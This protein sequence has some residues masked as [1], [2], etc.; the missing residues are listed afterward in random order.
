MGG[1]LSHLIFRELQ[2]SRTSVN[3][4]NRKGRSVVPRPSPAITLVL[5]QPQRTSAPSCGAERPLR[6][7]TITRDGFAAAGHAPLY[8]LAAASSLYADFPPAALARAIAA[9][10]TATLVYADPIALGRPDTGAPF[11]SIRARHYAPCPRIGGAR[12]GGLGLPCCHTQ[13]C[14]SQQRRARQLKRPTPGDGP[15]G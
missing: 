6:T 14:H 4:G 11:R 13:P 12:R 15:A 10:Q 1:R 3:K 7:H 8:T 2:P 5:A 9:P